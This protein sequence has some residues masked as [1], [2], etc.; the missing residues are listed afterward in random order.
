MLT[1]H[2]FTNDQTVLLQTQCLIS[3][4]VDKFLKHALLQHVTLFLHAS[5]YFNVGTLIH[6]SKARTT[7]PNSVQYVK[8]YH[9]QHDWKYAMPN[10][11]ANELK[12]RG[13]T[14]IEQALADSTEAIVSV[15]G[16][17]K[18]VVM[19]FEQYSHLRTCELEAAIHETRKDLAEGRFITESPAAHLKRLEEMK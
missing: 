16:K 14:A 18:Y 3:E 13:V 10:I 9:K 15:R 12:T 19:S 7:L 6:V 17:D 1:W 11:P 2:L 5:S 8:L 4:P